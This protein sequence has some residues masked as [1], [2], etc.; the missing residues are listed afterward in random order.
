MSLPFTK[1][2]KEAELAVLSVLRACHL[3]VH[4]SGS[5]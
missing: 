4:E 3:Y 1:Y 2:A 5:L